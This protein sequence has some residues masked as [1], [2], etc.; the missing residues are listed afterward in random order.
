M[1]TVTYATDAMNRIYRRQRH[2]YDFTRRYYLLGRNRLIRD[3]R[4]GFGDSV[5]EIG[6]GTARNLILAA[7]RYPDAY[8]FGVDVSTDMLTTATDSIA[9]AGLSAR[10]RVAHADATQFDPISIF[11]IADFERIF[12]SYCLSMIPGWRE[13]LRFATSLLAPGGELRVVDFGQQERLPAW[14]A[15]TLRAWLTLFHVTPRDDLEA[16]LQANA[17]HTGASLTF[18]SLYFGYAQ[19][20]CLQMGAREPAGGQA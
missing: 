7:R 9:R 4:P 18:N 12:A 19:Y 14:F 3:L 8:F 17:E 2:V 10:V 16:A 15:A 6:C 1:P 20:A 13:A 11:G 5:L